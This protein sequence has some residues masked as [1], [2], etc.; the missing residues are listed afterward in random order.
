MDV[1]PRQPKVAPFL[2]SSRVETMRSTLSISV[3]PYLPL[4]DGGRKP[5]MQMAANTIKMGVDL[6]VEDGRWAKHIG[7]HNITKLDIKVLKDGLDVRLR[8]IS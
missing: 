6:M 5:K 1:A 8:H 2:E 3:D 7:A 4:D